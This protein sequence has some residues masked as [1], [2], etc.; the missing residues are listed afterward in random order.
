MP[1]NIKRSPIIVETQLNFETILATTYGIE[2]NSGVDETARINAALAAIPFNSELVLET[3]TYIA[4]IEFSKDRTRLRGAGKPVWGGGAFGNNTTVLTGGTIIIP[5]P[6]TANLWQIDF[7]GFSHCGVT[8]L[9][10]DQS[11]GPNTL[12]NGISSSSGTPIN[13]SITNIALVGRGYATNDSIHALEINKGSKYFI[14]NLHIYR[15]GHGVAIK[16]PKCRIS[17]IYTYDNEISS[18]IVKSDNADSNVNVYNVFV[19]EVYAECSGNVPLAAAAITVESNENWYYTQDVHIKGFYSYNH[20]NTASAPVNVLAPA[21]TTSAY[22]QTGTTVTV[23]WNSH[24]FATG[25][26]IFAN[27]STGNLKSK[28]YKITGVTTNEFTFEAASATTSGNLSIDTTVGVSIKE[29]VIENA[30]N[31]RGFSFIGGRYISVSDSTV[32]NQAGYSYWN[33]GA[34]KVLLSNC[35]SIGSSS[36]PVTGTF[37]FAEVNGHNVGILKATTGAIDA[38]GAAG[39]GP[40]GAN[41][42]FVR[43]YKYSGSAGRYYSWG[44]TTSGNDVKL[45]RSSVAAAIGSETPNLDAWK[46]DAN[47]LFYPVQIAT[48]SIPAW[49]AGIVGAIVFDTTANKLKVAGAAAWETITSA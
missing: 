47:G 38:S 11:T 29:V 21:T 15:Y 36:S 40:S 45:Q 49:S 14:D 8:D 46:V 18:V 37:D 48:A 9:G 7:K 41:D 39:I 35:F 26:D 32:I 5:P 42:G 25:Q 34:T 4:T 22:S 30:A 43:L 2:P 13:T 31:D 12:I 44:L 23:T 10:L 1:L 19:D 3:G 6:D 16:V 20:L 24:Q 28:K 27:V 17:N 33:T